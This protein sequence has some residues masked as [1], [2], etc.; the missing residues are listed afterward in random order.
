MNSIGK[1]LREKLENVSAPTADKARGVLGRARGALTIRAKRGPNAKRCKSVQKKIKKL[2]EEEARVCEMDKKKTDF[3]P[4]NKLVDMNRDAEPIK[5]EAAPP[6]GAAPAPALVADDAEASSL[7]DVA[8]VDS[9]RVERNQMGGYLSRARGSRRRR[10]RRRRSS[11]KPK[12][13]KRSKRSNI[14]KAKKSK[15]RGR[16][17]R[18]SYKR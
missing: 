17:S 5:Q 11:K 13:S 18:R 4:A 1:T 14:K 8:D 2:Q 12:K 7:P 15:R 16:R 3:V 10:R 9:V 6:V